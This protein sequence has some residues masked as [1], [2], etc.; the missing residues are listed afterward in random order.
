MSAR[1]GVTL[2]REGVVQLGGPTRTVG[3]WSRRIGDVSGLTSMADDLLRRSTPQLRASSGLL[4]AVGRSAIRCYV[5][6][7]QFR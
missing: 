7:R 4:P 1:P 5:N 2:S 3:L 6:R